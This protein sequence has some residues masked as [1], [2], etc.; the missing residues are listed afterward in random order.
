MKGLSRKFLLGLVFGAIVCT[1]IL[2]AG[3][4][5]AMRA[6]I[7]QA[8]KTW[9]ALA[10]LCSV[11]VYTGRFLKWQLFL[12]VLQVKVPVGESLRIFL[13]GISMGITPGK[14]GEV[15]KSY[16]LTQTHGVPFS[17]TAPTIVAERLT[18]VLGCMLL[19][20][21]ALAV[22]GQGTWYSYV[23]CA[24]AFAISAAV[25]A[26]FRCRFFAQLVLDWLE[27]LAY[28]SKFSAALQNMYVS[29]ADILGARTLCLCIVLSMGYWFMECMVFYAVLSAFGLSY[30]LP[31]AV[32][33]LTALSIGGGLTLLPGSIGALEG[34]LIG[35]LVMQGAT[36]GVAAAVTLLHRFCAMWLYVLMGAVILLA[37]YRKCI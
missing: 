1:V 30:G 28:L 36:T 24:L 10:L 15:L 17:R 12:Q 23:V 6:A 8:D 4:A 34:G 3:D 2:L 22:L 25:L 27:R 32:L 7:I 16:L 20:L 19:C 26:F 18:G 29:F 14:V 35:V 11:G 33:I 13:S 5:D 31:Q 37:C 21:L 9:L